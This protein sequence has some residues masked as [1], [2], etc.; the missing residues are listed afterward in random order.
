MH[1]NALYPKGNS[2]YID[3]VNRAYEIM[4][5][6]PVLV[7]TESELREKFREMGKLL[8]PDAG[9][10]EGE[11]ATLREAYALLSSPGQ[12]LRH[13][14]ELRGEIGDLH[15]SI[16]TGLMD[17]F[18]TVGAVTQRVEAL[19][20]QRDLA[21]SALTKALLEDETQI[22]REAVASLIA[23]VEDSITQ[24]CVDFSS[25]E[26]SEKIDASVAWSRVRSLTFLEK[27]KASLRAS[28]ARLT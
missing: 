14:L 12:R 21:K 5:L 7:L 19:V 15:G 3:D 18:S 16:D 10:G 4:G 24:A 17:L 2:R 8:H 1:F 25:F 11:F 9:G 26:K 20:R 23:H 22:C 27:W 13:W 28:Y 6:Q